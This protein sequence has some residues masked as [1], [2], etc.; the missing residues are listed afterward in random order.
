MLAGCRA[1]V[2][3]DEALVAE[4]LRELLAEAEG[5]LGCINFPRHNP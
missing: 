3:E 5:G 4:S 1:L 2:V